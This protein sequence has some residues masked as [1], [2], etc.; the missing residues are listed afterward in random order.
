MKII[1]WVSE[2]VVQV[3]TSLFFYF[4]FQMSYSCMIRSL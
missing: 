2:V 3:R 1:G 4:R